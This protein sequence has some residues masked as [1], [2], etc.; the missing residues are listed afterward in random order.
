MYGHIKQ[1]A[2]AEAA[3]IRAAGGHADIYQIEE[4]LPKE[5]L[6]K[7]YAPTEQTGHTVR[8]RA[9]IRCAQ[10]QLTWK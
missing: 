3:G 5:V 1:L 10:G 2:E 4:T 8:E 7:M 6:Q 9:S